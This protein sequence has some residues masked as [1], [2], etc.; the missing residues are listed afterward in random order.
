MLPRST[1]LAGA[2]VAA[3]ALCI[4]QAALA[5]NL[6]K[7]VAV[8]RFENKTNVHGQW[9]LDSGM[10]DQLADALVQSGKFVV[11]ERQTLGDVTAEQDLVTAG[12]ARK[13]QS[14]QTGKLV[15]SQILIKGTVTEFEARSAGSGKSFGIGGFNIGSKRE[16][17]H[18]GLIIRLIDTTSG[19]ILASKRVEGKAKSGGLKWDASAMGVSMGSDGFTKTPLG[20]ATQIAI[21]NAV[22]IISQGLVNVPFQAHVISA[23]GGTVLINA[24]ERT[25]VSV[26][27]Q[28][29]VYGL[30][31]EIVDP[32]T[33]ESLGVEEEELGVIEITQVKEKYAKARPKGPLGAASPGD[34]VRAR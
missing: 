1:A 25:G 3:A 7:I 14:A 34:V 24:G 33:G 26:G 11:V 10:A 12:R 27:D 8:S 23:K 18:V 9:A 5:A 6:K 20:K 15:S 30:G 22:E 2:L 32:T 21:D 17:A 13:S 16:E 28:F 31:E 4:P 29:S 19:E